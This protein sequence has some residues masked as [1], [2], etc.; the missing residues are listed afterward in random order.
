MKQYMCGIWFAVL[1]VL[2]E[3]NARRGDGKVYTEEKLLAKFTRKV[4]R[5]KKLKIHKD[6]VKLVH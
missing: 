1:K 6:I 3:F 2:S 5:N 4:N